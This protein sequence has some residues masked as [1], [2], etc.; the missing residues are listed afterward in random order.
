MNSLSLQKLC[1][2]GIS[3]LLACNSVPAYALYK[4]YPIA[5]HNKKKKLL[6]L[7]VD[8]PEIN[9]EKQKGLMFR[10]DL[11][12]NTGML[13]LYKDPTPVNIWMKNTY[14]PLDILFFDK[15]GKITYIV[16]NAHPLDETPRGPSH[17][18]NGFLEVSA[19]T[20]QHYAINIGDVV[21]PLPFNLLK[22]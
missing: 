20:V 19:G 5:I 2:L 7:T 22:E 17:K 15:E 1:I 16:E 14:I 9:A 4:N 12:E 10:K 3:L 8:I 18:S 13:F 11:P 21:F 6:Q